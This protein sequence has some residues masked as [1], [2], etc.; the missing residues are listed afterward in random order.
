MIKRKFAFIPMI[1][2]TWRN[3]QAIIWFQY[4]YFKKGEYVSLETDYNFDQKYILSLGILSIE[5]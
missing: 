5:F 1:V 3:T 4:Y 2:N